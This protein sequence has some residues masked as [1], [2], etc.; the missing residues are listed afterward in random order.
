MPHSRAQISLR[1]MMCPSWI[2]RATSRAPRAPTLPATCVQPGC[3]KPAFIDSEGKESPYCSRTC[4]EAAHCKRPNCQ[5]PRG[6]NEF[7]SKD[8]NRLFLNSN[9]PTCATPHCTKIAYVDPA[10]T[11]L[12][13][14]FCAMDAGTAT[15]YGMASG[16][17]DRA[18]FFCN[19]Y[20]PSNLPVS[21]LP[22]QHS[23]LPRFLIIY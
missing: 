11:K 16:L 19:V 2:A 3:T 15:S 20:D 21:I 17:Q 7:C 18:M 6:Q 9:A 4:Q 12:Q 14:T 5:R 8:C 1:K 13:G 22:N 23:I 10:K